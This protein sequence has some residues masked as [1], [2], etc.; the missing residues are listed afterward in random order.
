[1]LLFWAPIKTCNGTA[2]G[3]PWA[4]IRWATMAP[5]TDWPNRTVDGRALIILHDNHA[6]V[7]A[8]AVMIEDVSIILDP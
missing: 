8:N 3:G 2:W 7:F 5:D 1:M 6:R 4:A